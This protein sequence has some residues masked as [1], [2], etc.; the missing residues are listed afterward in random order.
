MGV[1]QDSAPQLGIHLARERED[2]TNIVVRD[3]DTYVCIDADPTHVCVLE[4]PCPYLASSLP[5][6]PTWA[7]EPCQRHIPPG[8]DA[9]AGLVLTVV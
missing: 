4:E 9:P 6:C 7:S 3:V 2:R 8:W 5:D 1:G